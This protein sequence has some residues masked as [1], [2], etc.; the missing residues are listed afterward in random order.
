ME[1]NYA[2]CQKQAWVMLRSP[3]KWKCT[4]Y[5]YCCD[6]WGRTANQ[7][8]DSASPGQTTETP[9]ALWGHRRDA[10]NEICVDNNLFVSVHKLSI[11]LRMHCISEFFIMNSCKTS[12]SLVLKHYSFLFDW[13]TTYNLILIIICLLASAFEKTEER[14]L[15]FITA[16]ASNGACLQLSFSFSY[17][18][19]A[20]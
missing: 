12:V 16:E 9:W 17:E 15:I 11:E 7:V 19:K 13:V 20:G 2:L 18:P 10:R 3:S 14:V 1:Q 8:C 5:H 6:V 4:H